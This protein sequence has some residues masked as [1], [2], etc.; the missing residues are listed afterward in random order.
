VC[1]YEPVQLDAL[2]TCKDALQLSKNLTHVPT[3]KAKPKLK[4]IS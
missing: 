3:I 1:G 2:E 4:A